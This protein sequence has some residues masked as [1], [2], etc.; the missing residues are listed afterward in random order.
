M[1][2]LGGHG[3]AEDGLGVILFK[4]LLLQIMHTLS[5]ARCE[6]LIKD[7]LSFMRFLGLGISTWSNPGRQPFDPSD[8]GTA[9]SRSGRNIS[10]STRPRQQLN[11]AETALRCVRN[12]VHKDPRLG[13]RTV[14]AFPLLL[15]NCHPYTISLP[16]AWMVEGW[17]G[18]GR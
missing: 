18:D 2:V 15:V 11:P 3:R 12:C 14:V 6:Y 1:K 8:L 4:V 16:S 7:R 17:C 9:C 5:D 10:K 13:R